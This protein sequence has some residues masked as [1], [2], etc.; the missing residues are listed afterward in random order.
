MRHTSGYN[1]FWRSVFDGFMAN[2][3]FDLGGKSRGVVEPLFPP[4]P[5][6]DDPSELRFSGAQTRGRDAKANHHNYCEVTD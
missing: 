2:L 1:I 5:K 3:R 4:M 6:G